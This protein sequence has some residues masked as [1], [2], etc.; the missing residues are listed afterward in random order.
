MGAHGPRTLT[1]AAKLLNVEFA[2]GAKE[3]FT[4]PAEIPGNLFPGQVRRYFVRA[5]ERHREV[6]R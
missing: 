1:A 3:I 5:S 2:E 6:Q 4:L